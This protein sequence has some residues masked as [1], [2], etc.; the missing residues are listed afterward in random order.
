[1]AIWFF[2]FH[3]NSK[4]PEMN[5]FQ[6]SYVITN[7]A[8]PCYSYYENIV[9]AA[10]GNLWFFM[11][12][13]QYEPD[14]CNYEPA[15]LT[16]SETAPAKFLSALES[17]LEVAISNNCPQ[18]T[19]IIHGLGNLFTDSVEEMTVVGSGLQQYASYGGLVISFDWPSYGEVDSG[20][21][22]GL[23][24]WSFPPPAKPG[25][26]RG[27]IGASTGAFTNLLAMLK[28]IQSDL[29]TINI[30]FICHSEGNYMMMVGMNVQ[31]E[32]TAFLNQ[33]LLVAADINNGALQTPDSNP[34]V[35]AG[36]ALPVLSLSNRVTV[37]FSSGDDV[38]PD[39]EYLYSADHNPNYPQRLGL[40]GPYSFPGLATGVWGVDCSSV[41]NDT[42]I[43]QIPQVPSGMD[44]HSAY[45]YIPQVLEDWAQTLN[46]ISEGQV[47]NRQA[48]SNPNDYTMTF[49]QPRSVRLRRKAAGA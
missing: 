32:T 23:G 14:A 42:T 34:P 31:S 45:F 37:Y 44:S 15:G 19:V 36:E 33:I 30:N 27:N 25:S 7:R 29:P 18:L 21:E 13:G 17:D 28:K 10:N 38:L 2:S 16:P 4:E 49:V 20:L 1:M 6:N 8:E 12:S 22:Y 3:M 43:Q 46:G 48:T 39:S 40:E 24:S 35:G 5:S 47:V 41:I 26:I 11:A 9:P